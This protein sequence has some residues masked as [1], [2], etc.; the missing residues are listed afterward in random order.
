MKH[1]FSSAKMTNQTL[2]A[3]MKTLFYR[4]IKKIQL[5]KVFPKLHIHK[6]GS[7]LQ[8]GSYRYTHAD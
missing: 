7:N 2:L 5:V 1:T 3:I 8:V 6:N 4:H